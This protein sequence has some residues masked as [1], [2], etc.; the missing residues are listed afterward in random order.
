MRTRTGRATGRGT[1]GLPNQ[2]AALARAPVFLVADGMGGHSW[3]RVASDAVV[4]AFDE[5]ADRLDPRGGSPVDEDD[6]CRV[7]KDAARAVRS[8]LIWDI[9]EAWH[10]GKE[11]VA[12]STVS[13]VILTHENS[14]PD[15]HPEPPEPAE[16][17]ANPDHPA[18]LTL[19]VGDSRTYLLRDGV[20]TPLTRDHS[21]VQRLVDAGDLTREEARRHPKRN[22]IT[23]A[24]GVGVRGGPDV[25]LVPARVGDRVMACSDGAIEALSE[26]DLATILTLD[27]EPLGIAK[28]LVRRAR[29]A[30]A[31]DDVTVVVVDAR[32]EPSDDEEPGA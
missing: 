9:A 7:I 31:T 24:I 4:S 16:H 3:G 32:P 18:W 2:D 10:H 25:T 27:L 26:D 20:L 30:G 1:T 11:F 14:E 22:I 19:N 28:E 6:V 21:H 15:Q 5:L 13:G 12:G 8:E 23:R 17:R 29:R